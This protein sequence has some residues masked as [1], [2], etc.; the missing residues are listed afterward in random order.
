MANSKQQ[1]VSRV[2]VREPTRLAFIARAIK[3][4]KFI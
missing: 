2:S 1:F 4:E 3:Y